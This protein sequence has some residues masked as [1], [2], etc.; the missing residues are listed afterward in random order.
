MSL[1]IYDRLWGL[2]EGACTKLDLLLAEY[3]SEGVLGNTYEKYVAALK[4][5]EQLKAKHTTQEARAT[6][7]EQFVTYFT[8]NVPNAPQNQQLSTLR[9]EASQA[10]LGVTA[11]VWSISLNTRKQFKAYFAIIRP[12]R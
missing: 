2:L 12:E 3:A 11:L 6:L 1:G 7:L 5:R 4:K 8:L 10:R 9:R